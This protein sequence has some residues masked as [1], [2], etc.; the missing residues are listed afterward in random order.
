MLHTAG[1]GER[2]DDAIDAIRVFVELVETEFEG[3]IQV[4]HQAGQDAK[5]EAKD[6]DGRG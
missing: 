6:V 1:F 4:D 3:H 2:N 5:S